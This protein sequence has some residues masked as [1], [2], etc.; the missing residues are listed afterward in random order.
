[1]SLAP[2]VLF[3]YNRPWHTEQTLAALSKND[4]AGESV[5]YIYADGAKKNATGEQIEKIKEVR[6]LIKSKQWCKEVYIIESDKNKGLADSIISGVTNIINQYGKVIV[7]EDDVI[8]SKGFLKFMNDALLLYEN[9]ENVAVI[10]AHGFFETKSSYF[11]TYGDCWGW[12]TWKKVWETTSW[13]TDLLLSK[14]EKLS[15]KKLRQFNFGNNPIFYKMLK[16]QKEGKI[17]SWAIKFYASNFLNN[18]LTFYPHKS[19]T[20]NIGLDEGTHNHGGKRYNFNDVK[21]LEY[22][23][24]IKQKVKRNKK[25]EKLRSKPYNKQETTLIRKSIKKITNKLLSYFG[26]KILKIKPIKEKFVILNNVYNTDYNKNVLVSYLKSPFLENLGHSHTNVWECKT[27][28]DIF[29]ELGYNVDVI[30]YSEQNYS[31]DFEKYQVIYGFGQPFEDV[32]YSNCSEKIKKIFYSTGCCPYYSN[33]QSVFKLMEFYKEKGII[34]PQSSRLLTNVWTLQCFMSDLIVVLGN[35]F[36][37]KTFLNITPNINVQHLPIFYW[38]V[39]DIDLSQKDYGITKRHFLWFGSSGLLHKGLDILIDIFSKRNDIFLHI[40]GASKSEKKFFDYYQPIIDRSSNIIEH[41]F[42]DI[43]SSEFRKLMNLC[44]FVLF[45][46]I[47][48]GGAPATVNVM[49]NGGLIPIISK[50]SGLDVEDFGYVF[51]DI[52]ENVIRQMINQALNLSE[53]E[54]YEKS[55]FVKTSVREYYK[56]ENYTK[57]LKDILWSV[58]K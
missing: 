18:R 14:I 38:D 34:L 26:Y 32:F 33:E 29:N 50:S 8:V 21:L 16:D 4:L 53:T 12:G 51:E 9:E 31:I 37:V 7:L 28:A 27:A 47:S 15:V 23:K 3:V 24:V 43:N 20:A 1:M 10:S 52:E 30:E 56:Y 40:C 54:L 19:L 2:I 55:N 35:D 13:D 25:A 46:S 57:N 36:V 17:D 5:L 48:E 42:L 58:L 49:A 41:G 6:N 44:A 39:Y 22:Q 11:M 45:P